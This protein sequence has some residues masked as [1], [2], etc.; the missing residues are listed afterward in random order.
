MMAAV[1]IIDILTEYGIKKKTE[2]AAKSLKYDKVYCLLDM[3]ATNN[4]HIVVYD[5]MTYQPLIQQCMLID[6]KS[7]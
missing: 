1:G 7:L 2:Y 4:H 6:L 3:S 5:R